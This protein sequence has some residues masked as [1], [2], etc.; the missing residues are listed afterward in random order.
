M[1]LV[2]FF[3]KNQEIFDAKAFII[4]DLNHTYPG[5]DI[6]ILEVNEKFNEKNERYYQVKAKVTLRQNSPCPERIHIYYNYPEQNFVPQTPEYI[7]KNCVV[8]KETPCKLVFPEEAIIA[9]HTSKGTED[10]HEF[11]TK[12]K[13]AKAF[14]SENATTWVV[15]WVSNSSDYNIEV[16]LSKDAKVLSKTKLLKNG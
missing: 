1:A 4:E 16:T 15:L 13:D 2:E 6:E 11:V 7:T 14:A 10:V 8:C 3:K 5:A 12:Y 9:S